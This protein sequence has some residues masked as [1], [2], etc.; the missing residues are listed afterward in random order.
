VNKNAW[1]AA[2]KDIFLYVLK[3]FGTA[4]AVSKIAAKYLITYIL[5]LTG[6]TGYIVGL[7]LP[8]LIEWGL[9]ELRELS[10]EIKDKKTAKDLEK[11]LPNGNT[12]KRKELEKSILEGK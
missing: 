7:V 9:V 3:G 6:P 11:E 1:L 2:L 8:K 10:E 5:K 4:K 12:D